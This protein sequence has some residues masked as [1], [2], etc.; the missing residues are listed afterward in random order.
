MKEDATLMDE[1]TIRENLKRARV[2]SGLTQTEMAERIGI[3][4]TAY[5][6]IE[7]GRTRILNTNYSKCAEVLGVSLSELVNGFVPVRDAAAVIEDVRESY[8][9]KMRVQESGYLNEVQNKDRE[10]GRLKDVIKDKE[11]TIATQKLLIDQLLSRL[12]K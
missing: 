3:S 6:K 1:I 2:S 9:L 11:D 12:D 4:V 7:S 5:Q 10:I 8:G